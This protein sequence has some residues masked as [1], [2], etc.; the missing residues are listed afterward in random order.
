MNCDR[1][2]WN[3]LLDDVYLAVLVIGR[4]CRA[5]PSVGFDGREREVPA[6][7]YLCTIGRPDTSDIFRVCIVTIWE[8]LVEFWCQE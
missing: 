4:A 7:I 3:K 6:M 5:F 2:A 1:F 8:L